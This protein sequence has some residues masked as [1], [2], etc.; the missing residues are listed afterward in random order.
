MPIIIKMI[1]HMTVFIS[2]SEMC[3]HSRSLKYVYITDVIIH[4]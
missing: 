3:I 4:V 1:P 2:Y